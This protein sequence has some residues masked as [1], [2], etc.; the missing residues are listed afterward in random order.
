[1]DVQTSHGEWVPMGTF[2][3]ENLPLLCY[4]CGIVGY[5]RK[6]FLKTYTGK[7]GSMELTDTM[8]GYSGKIDISPRALDNRYILLHAFPNS[9]E[10]TRYVQFTKLMIQADIE[11]LHAAPAS[12]VPIQFFSDEETLKVPLWHTWHLIIK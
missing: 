7:H 3:H 6:Y 4:R 2:L 1:M 10:Y 9:F 5:H 11:A 12:S 8:E